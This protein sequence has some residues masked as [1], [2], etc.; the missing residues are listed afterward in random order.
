MTN[1]N[2]SPKRQIRHPQASCK[3]PT[4]HGCKLLFI[5]PFPP[6]S[7]YAD[8]GILSLHFLSFP[9]QP[10]LPYTDTGATPMTP[11][12]GDAHPAVSR[13]VEY[14]RP[15]RN[16]AHYSSGTDMA[17]GMVSSGNNA[18][19]SSATSSP[20][21]NQ[22]L[23]STATYG[24]ERGGHAPSSFRSP[25]ISSPVNFDSHSS[26]LPSRA[27]PAPPGSSSRRDSGLPTTPATSSQQ[28][29]SAG[30]STRSYSKS[31]ANSP[32][33]N[34]FS[35]GA[36][37]SSSSATPLMTSSTINSTN[38][39]PPPRPTR[40]GTLPLD[41]QTNG[42]SP[43]SPPLP[44]G[45]DHPSAMSPIGGSSFLTQPVPPALVHQPFSAPGNPYAGQSLERS[46]EE[47]KIGLG[48]GLPMNVGEPKDKDL[49]TAPATSRSRSG[50]GKSQKGKSI[51]GLSFSGELSHPSFRRICSQLTLQTCWAKRKLLSSPPHTIPFIL[52]MLASTTTPGN[53]GLSRQLAASH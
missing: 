15:S 32:N 19:S 1:V 11:S 45:R 24:N 18:N 46:L 44:G 21:V 43:I 16:S 49:P 22:N 48:M 40:A 33:P 42:L 12:N 41:S 25:P 27:A 6:C 51:F 50:T 35:A 8:H 5:T 23:S 20:R 52:H 34:R 31:A 3:S 4:N 17:L 39:F 36:G 30:P 29:L 53:V 37:P 47:T 13:T 14:H 10:L 38:G 2:T 28:P 7:H 9:R 26:M